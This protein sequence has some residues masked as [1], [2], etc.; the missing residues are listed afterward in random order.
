MPNWCFNNLSVRGSKKD[1]ERFVSNFNSEN[2]KKDD[3]YVR[4]NEIYIYRQ[5]KRSCRFQYCTRYDPS[6]DQLLEFLKDYPKMSFK[7]E[8]HECLAGFQGVMKSKGGDVK[9]EKE[10]DYSWRDLCDRWYYWFLRMIKPF[11]Y[12]K[13]I[14]LP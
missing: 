1:V 2:L 14:N 7:L 12:P 9:Y 6:I 13:V 3:I 11:T 10:E 8:Y 5:R 4:M